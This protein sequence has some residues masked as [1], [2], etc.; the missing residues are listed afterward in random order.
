MK[1]F[2]DRD[3]LLSTN[4]AKQL[5]HDYAEKMPIIDYHCHIN[6]REIALNR[7]YENITQLWLESDHY[8]WRL[9][10]ANGVEERYITG[11]ADDFE[12][13]QKWAETLEKAIGNPIYHWS[14][15][16][17][18]KYFGYSGVLNGRTAQKV[19]DF[20]CNKIKKNGMSSR[21]IIMQSNVKLI[22]TTDDPIDSLEWHKAIEKDK[23]FKT[24]VLPAWR[25]DNTLNIEKEDYTDYLKQLSC[26]SG[27]TINDYELLKK[28]LLVRM[29]YFEKAG[30]L[31]SDHG[32]DYIMYN[33]AGENEVADIFKKRMLGENINSDEVLKF[34]TAL[35]LF[36]GN[37]YSKRNWVMQLHFGV[38][39]NNNSLAYKQLGA[40]TGFDA[41]NPISSVR[42]LPEFLDAMTSKRCL[43]KTI[44][45]SLNPNDNTA[46]DT[47]MGCFQDSP[48]VEGKIQHGCAWWFN[49]NKTGMKEHMI[50]LANQG[51]LGNFIG[52]LTDSR[53]LLSYTRHEYFRRIL[54][55]LVGNWVEDGEYYYDIDSLVKIVK[56]ISYNN[57]VKYFHLN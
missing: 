35:M 21:S 50:S 31:I 39:R 22:C 29:D 57:S 4:T 36:L 9:M 43:P 25:P 13:F 24:K 5:Y 10:R 12:K 18:Q 15:M 38:K 20:C 47:I 26:V 37:E 42:Q 19:W 1:K 52:M 16:E 3:F 32:M 53:S 45:Y 6:P 27:I 14:H 49:D 17:L 33:P 7:K 55:D 34:K 44:L 8:K 48:G 2:M 54:C 30:C 23:E 40:D 41:I 11:D 56:D 51:L 46:I 28:A